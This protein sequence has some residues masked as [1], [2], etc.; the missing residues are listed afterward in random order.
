[1]K[2]TEAGKFRHRGTI[3]VARE[4][5]NTKGNPVVL[6][7]AFAS[8]LPCRV[9]GDGRE[10]IKRAFDQQLQGQYVTRVSLRWLDG[11]TNGMRFIWHDRNGDRTFSIVS[12]PLNPDGVNKEMVL[13]IKEGL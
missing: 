6:W 8:R 2:G 13:L 9:G 1:M 5:N 12:Q 4:T 3:Q 7:P 11:V 10:E